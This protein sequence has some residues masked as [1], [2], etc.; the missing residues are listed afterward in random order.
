M[1]ETSGCGTDKG[2]TGYS[3]CNRCG[4]VI[5]PHRILCDICRG[6]PDEQ[7][8]NH[9]LKRVICDKCRH[10][11][12]EPITTIKR[13]ISPLLASQKDSFIKILESKRKKQLKFTTQNG[14]TNA[15]IWGYNQALGD[16]KAEL[17]REDR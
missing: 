2:F 8:Y 3:Y 5:P 6:L 10:P 13:F 4:E 1:N 17:E 9:S 7:E 16:I 12:W 14:M 15:E 11:H